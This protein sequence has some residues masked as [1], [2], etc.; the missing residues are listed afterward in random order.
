MVL[1]TATGKVDG[2]LIRMK[3]AD[4]VLNILIGQVFSISSENQKLKYLVSMRLNRDVFISQVF[5]YFTHTPPARTEIAFAGAKMLVMKLWRVP[6]A[7]TQELMIDFYQRLLALTP[8]ADALREAQLEIK[9]K[10]PHPLDWGAFICQ[11]DP[12]PA[13]GIK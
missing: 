5:Q 3:E 4:A 10:Y 12:G 8:K 7:P 1:Y 13:P 11:G 9:K 6:D 2:G